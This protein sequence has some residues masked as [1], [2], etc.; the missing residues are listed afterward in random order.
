ML[1]AE[2]EP[3]YFQDKLGLIR[4]LASQNDLEWLQALRLQPSFGQNNLS[5]GWRKKMHE[6]LP[7]LRTHAKHISTIQPTL[8]LS[9]HILPC[10]QSKKWYSY[11]KCCPYVSSEKCHP[12]TYHKSSIHPKA[13]LQP[14]RTL[15]SLL[16]SSFPIL[17][18]PLDVQ[19]N[20]RKLGRIK[21]RLQIKKP[22]NGSHHESSLLKQGSKM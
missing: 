14:A 15:L 8:Q 6:R 13:A 18:L 3:F 10:F 19:I 5:F 11:K 21:S 9:P 4:I 12:Q 17:V 16:T 20:P 1:G 2:R 22:G 7:Q